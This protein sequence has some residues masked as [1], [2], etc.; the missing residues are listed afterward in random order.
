[1]TNVR[2]SSAPGAGGID[3]VNEY[4]RKRVHGEGSGSTRRPLKGRG[5]RGWK[6][7]HRDQINALLSVEEG[8]RHAFPGM[9]TAG[10][11]LARLGTLS[12][13]LAPQEMQPALIAHARNAVF[14]SERWVNFSEAGG[15]TRQSVETR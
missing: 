13:F 1:M 10:D 3:A 12:G 11:F 2:L 7:W 9:L 4:I 15:S 5:L 6:V 8:I 14:K